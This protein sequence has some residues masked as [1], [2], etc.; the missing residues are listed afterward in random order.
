MIQ[1]LIKYDSLG[2]QED[3]ILSVNGNIIYCVYAN[4]LDD[5]LFLSIESFD[6]GE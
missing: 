6:L 1:K 5:K 2:V 4:G 3:L